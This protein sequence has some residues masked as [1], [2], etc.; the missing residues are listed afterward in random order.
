[1]AQR[2]DASA[3]QKPR[4]YQPQ[5]RSSVQQRAN[6]F[7]GKQA[8]LNKYRQRSLARTHKDLSRKRMQQAHR[9]TQH[10]SVSQ[11]SYRSRSA[12]PRTH[13]NL[14]TRNPHNSSRR[15]VAH[16]SLSQKRVRQSAAPRTHRNL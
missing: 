7:R 8:G 9:R 5:G 2:I 16:N 1:M 15:P 6:R 11:R 12:G 14:S 4:I 3:R 13:R 10:Q